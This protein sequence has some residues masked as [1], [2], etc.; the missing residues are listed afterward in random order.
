MNI[1][2]GEEASITVLGSSTT[3]FRKGTTPIRLV[4][5]LGLKASNRIQDIIK[6]KSQLYK[7][8]EKDLVTDEIKVAENGTSN[9]EKNDRVI[10]RM[11]HQVKLRDNKQKT[12]AEQ[13][14]KDRI[15]EALNQ[16]RNKSNTF[17]TK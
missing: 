14:S 16:R 7:V 13:D 2:N 15:E 5:K 17:G 8:E 6:Q 3:D 12:K 4:K 11:R 10:R 9:Y 1:N